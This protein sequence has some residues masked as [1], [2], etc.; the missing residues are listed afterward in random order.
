MCEIGGQFDLSGRAICW[1]GTLRFGA[2]CV[3]LR[4]SLL[5]LCALEVPLK[6][7]TGGGWVDLSLHRGGRDAVCVCVCVHGG[8]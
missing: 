7:E 8:D 5:C 1:C 3:Y 2:K 4:V 6:Q